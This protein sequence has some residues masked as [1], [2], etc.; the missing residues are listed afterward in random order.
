MKTS[1]DFDGVLS[2][3]KWQLVAKKFIDNGDDVW[4]TTSREP[5]TPEIIKRYPWIER[6]N[7][8]LFEISD[9][10]GIARDKIQFTDH[11]DKWKVLD[12]FDLH[13]DDDELEIELLEENLP[14]CIGIRV[15]KS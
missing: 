2:E 8:Q 9:K 12:S 13:F 5:S 1:F 10:L 11:V 6:Q 4:I 15:Y 14:S 3:E 7:K